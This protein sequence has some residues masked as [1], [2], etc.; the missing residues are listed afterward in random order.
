MKTA[1][2]K[3]LL[4]RTPNNF[5]EYLINHHTGGT[6][7]N[8][9]ADT[10]RHTAKTVENW[11]LRKGWDGIGY[12]FYID[13]KG[14][15]WLGRPEHVNGA[16]AKGYNTKSLGIC[17]AGNFDA[18]LPTDKQKESLRLLLIDL[19]A[20]YGINKKKI[21][22]HRHVAN[23]TCYGTL[24]ADDWARNLLDEKLEDKTRNNL[25]KIIIELLLKLIKQRK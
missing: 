11:H 22:P 6:N 4:N 25:L 21:I 18:T 23:K 16:H 1:T 13:I 3:K 24:L 8:P 5:P 20:K 15:V 12:H 7:A 19:S 2:Y 17:M 14:I 10:S 9:L